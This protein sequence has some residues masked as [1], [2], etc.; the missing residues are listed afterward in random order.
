MSECAS[1]L[2]LSLIANPA[3]QI[4]RDC[5]HLASPRIKATSSF[6]SA[7]LTFEIGGIRAVPHTPLPPL[8]ILVINFSVAPASPLYLTATAW[9]AGPT[10]FLPIAWQAVQWY[11]LAMLSKQSGQSR[12][13]M[14][15][16][17]GSVSATFSDW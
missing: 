9:K 12:R 14:L 2:S 10:T 17:V 15:G 6:I 1:C 5:A 16:F 4:L 13:T 3:S 11:F 7:S 8:A